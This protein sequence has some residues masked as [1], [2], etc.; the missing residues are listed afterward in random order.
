MELGEL[1]ES[2]G[3]TQLAKDIAR[4]SDPVVQE[5]TH[6]L[7]AALRWATPSKSVHVQYNEQGGLF[8]DVPHC[9]PT[10][11]EVA[12]LR[13]VA[14]WVVGIL[15]PYLPEHSKLL[16]L[17]R[18]MRTEVSSLYNKVFGTTQPDVTRVWKSRRSGTL[19]NQVTRLAYS[20]LHATGDA[21][22]GGMAE[23][24]KHTLLLVP[25]TEERDVSVPVC[26]ESVSFPVATAMVSPL[27]KSPV[28]CMFPRARDAYPAAAQ[29][30][31]NTVQEALSMEPLLPCSRSPMT[32]PFAERIPRP[33][34]VSQEGSRAWVCSEGKVF[35]D[36]Y[37]EGLCSAKIPHCGVDFHKLPPDEFRRRAVK[38]VSPRSNT[39]AACALALETLR[40]WAHTGLWQPH[41]MGTP[42]AG[43]SPEAV[44]V[45]RLCGLS[46]VL[47]R[48]KDRCYVYDGRNYTALGEQEVL[49]TLL[50]PMRSVT[51]R[52]VSS[53]A[54]WRSLPTDMR[55]PT[56]DEETD[57]RISIRMYALRVGVL[58]Q[59]LSG[60]GSSD[61]VVNVSLSTLERLERFAEAAEEAVNLTRSGDELETKIVLSV[62]KRSCRIR[63]ATAMGD[64]IVTTLAHALQQRVAVLLS[65]LKSSIRVSARAPRTPLSAVTDLLEPYPRDVGMPGDDPY[66]K[67]EALGFRDLVYPRDVAAVVHTKELRRYVPEFLDGYEHE[68]ARLSPLL[69]AS[70]ALYQRA[71]EQLHES[72]GS[73]QDA[74][75]PELAPMLSRRSTDPVWK[76]ISSVR[77]VVRSKDPE[78]VRQAEKRLRIAY[79]TFTSVLE[80]PRTYATTVSLDL[81]KS[82]EIVEATDRSRAQDVAD[83]VEDELVRAAAR[84]DKS[85]IRSHLPPTDVEDVDAFVR[86]HL[87]NRSVSRP[88]EDTGARAHS[89]AVDL[90]PHIPRDTLYVP[91]DILAKLPAGVR[92][93]HVVP[94]VEARH[95]I[96]ALT[97]EF[98]AVARIPI[99]Y[100]RYFN[101]A[102]RRLGDASFAPSLR[103]GERECP[104]CLARIL[105]SVEAVC[106]ALEYLTA[107]RRV[108]EDRVSSSRVGGAVPAGSGAVGL[109]MDLCMTLQGLEV[110]WNDYVQLRKVD[111]GEVQ[112]VVDAESRPELV[113]SLRAAYLAVEANANALAVRDT[114]PEA[115]ATGANLGFRM[116]A[117]KDSFWTRPGPAPLTPGRQMDLGRARKTFFGDSSSG[118]GSGAVSVGRDVTY[119]CTPFDPG[120][121]VL[122]QAAEFLDEQAK[123]FWFQEDPPIV[124]IERG[125]LFDLYSNDTHALMGLAGVVNPPRFYHKRTR[126]ALLQG[127]QLWSVPDEA[128]LSPL[129]ERRAVAA[130]MQIRAD[131][132]GEHTILGNHITRGPYYPGN[133]SLDV[134]GFIWRDRIV[135]F[136]ASL[137]DDQQDI[138]H[139]LANGSDAGPFTTHPAAGGH[140]VH[141]G[142]T[143]GGLEEPL[144]AMDRHAA[145]A[146]RTRAHWGRGSGLSEEQIHK[147]MYKCV[148]SK[149]FRRFMVHCH[150]VAAGDKAS[151]FRSLADVEEAADELMFDDITAVRPRQ[152]VVETR[153][154]ANDPTLRTHRTHSLLEAAEEEAHTIADKFAHLFGHV[155]HHSI[156]EALYKG[157]MDL[158]DDE[159][160]RGVLQESYAR[161]QG[162][163]PETIKSM[164]TIITSSAPDDRHRRVAEDIGLR[165]YR[166]FRFLSRATPAGPHA[167]FYRP[168]GGTYCPPG[169]FYARADTAATQHKTHRVEHWVIH[170][171][172]LGA[173]FPLD[174][175]TMVAIF[176]SVAYRNAGQHQPPTDMPRA[177]VNSDVVTNQVARMM[178]FP[179]AALCRDDPQGASALQVAMARDPPPHGSKR[180]Q[181]V[182]SY[183][184]CPDGIPGWFVLPGWKEVDKVRAEVEMI[185]VA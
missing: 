121:S 115:L 20:L 151:P 138:L 136:P 32:D 184:L 125:Q 114:R 100:M 155:T 168:H 54:A 74:S 108:P 109:L 176:L 146:M 21:R 97:R 134:E 174:E 129:R 135:L 85:A 81:P 171:S 48:G 39:A 69:Y 161:V 72:A 9:T 148:T 79:L 47:L 86:S 181:Q 46:Q 175:D 27:C 163:A 102:F 127:M 33:R 37:P 122:A 112:V 113:L 68:G 93:K 165:I 75:N 150:P 60:V 162:Q 183:M 157:N 119:L 26:E 84:G 149:A 25:D 71:L 49:S 96:S 43:P 133:G 89:A 158:V 61:E 56:R 83:V 4:I 139:T 51:M 140:H 12:F 170:P 24:V 57:E 132:T 166:A 13:L 42:V 19:A 5:A 152:G 66:R 178:R 36:V 95:N 99:H 154:M 177:V 124:R 67:G 147:F 169:Q 77:H 17:P 131:R 167:I 28:V 16:V 50:A 179:P 117:P 137:R 118:G 88:L 23:S 58:K 116:D 126:A 7:V 160:A 164:K 101:E 111:R 123:D 11:A 180:I 143:Q 73:A 65:D 105:R 110:S 144:S 18:S 87:L 2:F 92:A 128:D 44:P 185:P 64:E 107:E 172:V 34:E 106:D 22:Y 159:Q 63:L 98:F 94:V 15:R 76:V 141:M 142:S 182:G 35:L 6:T 91:T 29:Y 153:R 40:I 31:A 59:F 82:A 70:V 120:D 145:L 90:L 30:T 45:I 3:H 103:S 173:V 52:D 14:R 130:L 62:G 55:F 156:K 10:I 1:T 8:P 80:P 38:R 41:A 78:A 104:F 53:L